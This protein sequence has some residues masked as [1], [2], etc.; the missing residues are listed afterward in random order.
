LWK[1]FSGEVNIY[2]TVPEVE[3]VQEEYN[4]KVKTKRIQKSS[5]SPPY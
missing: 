4:F 3:I 5:G 1:V 2:A